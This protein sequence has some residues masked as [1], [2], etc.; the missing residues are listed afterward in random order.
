MIS[1]FSFSEQSRSIS[2]CS[3]GTS[4]TD[5]GTTTASAS[6]SAPSSSRPKMNDQ[7]RLLTPSSSFTLEHIVKMDRLN[8]RT[9]SDEDQADDGDEFEVLSNGDFIN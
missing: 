6:A 2:A 5:I 3:T 4:A 1:S 8:I 7:R 9:P